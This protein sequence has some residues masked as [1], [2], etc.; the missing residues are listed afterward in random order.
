MSVYFIANIQLKDP[1]LYQNYLD[2]CDEVF[3]KY[4]G[5]YLAVD[6]KPEVLE[7]SWD[8]SKT[9]I[10]QFPSE[11]EFQRWYHSEEYQAILKYRLDAAV[12]D[13]ILVRG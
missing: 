8:Y 4:Q 9:V 12:C 13:T 2:N 1:A 7:G 10:I 6:H 3:A 11:E 5:K